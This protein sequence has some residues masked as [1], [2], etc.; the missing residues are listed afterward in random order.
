MTAIWPLYTLGFII[1]AK[2]KRAM[3]ELELT[4]V[5]AAVRDTPGR[6]ASKRPG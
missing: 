2:E 5:P 3:L 1:H 4:A 6:A